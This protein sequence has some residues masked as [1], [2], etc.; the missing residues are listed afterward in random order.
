MIGQAFAGMSLWQDELFA[1]RTLG[2][3]FSL[4]VIQAAYAALGRPGAGIPVVHVVGTNGKGS[5]SAMVAHA[6]ARR[7]RRVGLYTSPHLHR[8]GER[9]RVDGAAA[10]DAEMQAWIA[11]VLAAEARGL[12]RA[13]TF[14]E[15]LTVAA[16]LAFARAG[17][18]VMVLE[19]GLGGRLDATRVLP[20]TVTLVTPIALDHQVFLGDTVEAIAG[21]KAAVMADGA[22]AFSAPQVPGVAAVLRAAAAEHGVPL[23]FVAPLERGPIGLA[24]EHQRVNA[25]LALAGARA[26]DPGVVAEDLDGVR[27]PGRCERAQL[28]RGTAVFDASHNPHGVLALVTWLK[29]Q[30]EAR[31]VIAFGCLADKDAPVMLGHLRRLGA[32]LWLVPPGPGAYPTATLAGPDTREFAGPDDPSLR[33]A[34]AE[35]L[36]GGG[37]L[38]VCGSHAL[39]G[40]LRG[41]LLAQAEDAVALADPLT[42]DPPRP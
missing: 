21:E 4:D 34:C 10:S 2:V 32:P 36:A 1:R 23:A 29:S 22:P 25:A 38:V 18:E 42:R 19:A 17:V 35:H 26:I 8:V 14:F 33:A 7:G 40:R 41:E 15:V 3:R 6:L 28:V 30:P 5:T 39:V 9:I 24:G 12:P 31:R 20:A 27:W 13:L 16:L 11:E 37:E